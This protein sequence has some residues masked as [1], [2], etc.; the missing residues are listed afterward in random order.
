MTYIE[1]AVEHL[2]QWADVLI[3]DQYQ[4]SLGL[5]HFRAH[6]MLGRAGLECA[7]QAVW[8]LAPEDSTLRLLR[9]LRLMVVDV[10]EEIKALKSEGH[11]QAVHTME[12]L[13]ETMRQ[14]ASSNYSGAA[15]K[16]IGYRDIIRQAAEELGGNPG[17]SE[18]QWMRASAAAHGRKW[19]IDYA[20]DHETLTEGVQEPLQLIVPRAAEV[21]DVVGAGLNALDAAVQLYCFRGGL[22]YAALS[23]KGVLYAICSTPAAPGLEDEKESYVQQIEA[24]LEEKAVREN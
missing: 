10:G 23:R 16:H 22:D 17:A 5:R 6:L 3:P 7:S 4:E 24:F 1:S 14:H 21:L 13:I 15:L 8:V 2:G 12:T 9:H 20:Y 11:A 19:L 18:L